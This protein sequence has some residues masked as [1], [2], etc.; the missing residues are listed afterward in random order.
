VGR[1]RGGSSG[2]GRGRGRQGLASS[3]LPLAYA[4]YLGGREEG[5]AGSGG[6]ATGPG[7]SPQGDGGEGGPYRRAPTRARRGARSLKNKTV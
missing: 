2:G 4:R 7:R 6:P 3:S 1:A 5:P